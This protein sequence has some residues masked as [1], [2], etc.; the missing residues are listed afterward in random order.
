MSSVTEIPAAPPAVA[1]A[2]FESILQF[3]TDCSDVHE[4]LTAGATDFIL[5]D[6]R[7]P[8]EFTQG[9]IA[10]AVNVPGGQITQAELDAYPAETVFVIYSDLPHC[11]AAVHAAVRLARIGRPVKAMT[12]GLTGWREEGFPVEQFRSEAD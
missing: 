9:H 3:E 11:N 4:A 12:G 6:V 7:G 5:L 10:G 8:D 1:L 2:H